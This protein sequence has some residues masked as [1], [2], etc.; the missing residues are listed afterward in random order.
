MTPHVIVF[1]PDGDEWHVLGTH[2]AHVGMRTWDG[3]HITKI[4]RT[5]IT[6]TVG[7]KL[8]LWPGNGCVAL[9]LSEAEKYGFKR[10]DTLPFE[11]RK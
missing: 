4:G 7:G 9:T 10:P 6:V 3:G 2:P 11:R 1:E 5:R 8:K